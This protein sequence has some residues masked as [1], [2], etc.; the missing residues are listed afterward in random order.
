[1][2]M[3]ETKRTCVSGLKLKIMAGKAEI[4]SFAINEQ[5]DVLAEFEL[6]EGYPEAR[7]C[8]GQGPSVDVLSVTADQDITLEGKGLTLTIHKGTNITEIVDVCGA[9]GELEEYLLKQE[10][11]AAKKQRDEIEA[12]RYHHRYHQD[13]MWRVA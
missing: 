10:L 1:M 9:K 2:G 8:P 13:G 11:A 6:D 7:D 12:D 3:S 5:I 4:E